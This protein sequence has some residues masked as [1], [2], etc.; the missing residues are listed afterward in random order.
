MDAIVQ[1]IRNALCCIKDCQLFPDYGLHDATI[2]AKLF[3]DAIPEPIN[4]TTPLEYL[5]CITQFYAFVSGSI[6]GI[7]KIS[8]RRYQDIEK[9]FNIWRETKKEGGKAAQRVIAESLLREMEAALRSLFVGMCVFPLGFS[10]LWLA[11]NSLHITQTN[12]I[13]GLPALIHALTVM[14]IFLVPLLYFMYVDGKSYIKASNEVKEMKKHLKNSK[15]YIADAQINAVTYKWLVPSW[16]PFWLANDINLSDQIQIEKA[17]AKE[18][19]EVEENVIELENKDGSKVGMAATLSMDSSAWKLKKEG[20]REFIYF[21]LNLIAFYGYFLGILTYYYPDATDGSNSY[22]VDILKL[23]L[24]SADAD[25]H[26]N[27]AGDFM[28]TIEP[29]IIIFSPFY[30]V[31]FSPKLKIKEE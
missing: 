16:S 28:W 10:F 13:G 31:Q 7:K 15:G 11:A 3:G 6:G 18:L 5:I 2:P 26:G 20:E 30:F 1:F 23:G 8:S 22:Y 17:F 14:E 25:W 19:K 21:I 29:L 9:L 24:S 12:W 27:F 4:L